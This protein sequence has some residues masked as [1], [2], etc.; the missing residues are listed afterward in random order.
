MA[1]KNLLQLPLATTA[2]G[3]LVYGIQNNID[4]AIPA[5]VLQGSEQ[6]QGANL[7]YAGPPTAPG[8]FPTFRPLVQADIPDLSSLYLSSN[9]GSLVG[10]TINNSTFIG[11][12][13]SGST[14]TFDD[15]KFTLRD[16]LDTTKQAR[17]ELNGIAAGTLRTFT[18]P[19][20]STVI[21]GTNAQQDLTNK[22]LVTV[23]GTS[24]RAPVRIPHGQA[25]SAPVNGDV[26][27]TNAG[28][29]VQANN[30]TIGP[31]AAAASSTVTTFNGR[32]GA[33]TL[34]SADVTT[35]IGFTPYNPALDSYVLKAG[36]TMS[37]QLNVPNLTVASTGLFGTAGVSNQI[38]IGNI[39]NNQ[40]SIRVVNDSDN[41][42]APLIFNSSEFNMNGD[43]K[44]ASGNGTGGIRLVSAGSTT[45]YIDHRND[46][47][48]DTPNAIA[49]SRAG[50]YRWEAGGGVKM[51]LDSGGR[52]DVFGGANFKS[53]GSGGV[54]NYQDSAGTIPRFYNTWDNSTWA[55][56]GMNDS[57]GYNGTPLRLYRGTNN[58][59]C[60]G[61]ITADGGFGPG[62]DPRLKD[63][64]SLKRVDNALE[65]VYNLNVRYGKYHEWFN[66]DGK[67]RVFLMADKNMAD[68]APQ[69]FQKGIIER[70]ED[71][72]DGW[73]ADQMIALLT[74]A[75][76]ELTDNCLYLKAEIKKLKENR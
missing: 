37:G 74:K 64:S 45:T 15:D 50:S 59:N 53:Q 1:D 38:R 36:D 62:S 17:F 40:A 32:Q 2:A 10:A 26:W 34:T 23:A 8:G 28:M 18:F 66:S 21:V 31:L 76:Q 55:M 46:I 65:K 13:I 4:V 42:F 70:D 48:V 47:N 56:N 73:S 69:V 3:A 68:N 29:Y 30:A 5:N 16:Q 63:E 35:A 39:G 41:A 57:G 12:S 58:L 67:E 43:F 14:A 7:V 51:I 52:L 61:I 19:D 9:G 33:V 25:P 27:T 20:I 22:T 60:G 49:V 71:K 44:V 54:I 24:A 75:V 6:P 72:Y 11:G